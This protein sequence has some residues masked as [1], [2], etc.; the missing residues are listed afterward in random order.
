MLLDIYVDFFFEILELVF[1]LGHA[2]AGAGPF[3]GRV[4]APYGVKDLGWLDRAA[5][6]FTLILNRFL[7]PIR[8]QNLPLSRRLRPRHILIRLKIHFLTQKHIGNSLWRLIYPVHARIHVRLII[9]VNCV[10]Q[11]ALFHLVLQAQLALLELAVCSLGLRIV[12][13][14]AEV[15]FQNVSFSF[16][17]WVGSVLKKIGVVSDGMIWG[18]WRRVLSHL[19]FLRAKACFSGLLDHGHGVGAVLWQVIRMNIGQCISRCQFA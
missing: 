4:G 17:D 15:L 12:V 10:P 8:L 18:L 5:V 7:N 2:E 13:K 1:V 6:H 9:R 14:G 3:G 11:Q 16:F 19:L